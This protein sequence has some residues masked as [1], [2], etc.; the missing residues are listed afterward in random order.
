MQ[1][2]NDEEEP[3]ITVGLKTHPLLA[4]HS[5][6]L[7]YYLH[8]R[9]HHFLLHTFATII[10]SLTRCILDNHHLI[11]R[12]ITFISYGYVLHIGECEKDLPVV[13]VF[14]WTALGVHGG[15]WLKV[16]MSRLLPKKCGSKDLNFLSWFNALAIAVMVPPILR[17]F[18]G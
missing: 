1:T 5:P 8:A 6:Y 13:G 18:S 2:W 12:P 11:T 14:V 16:A 17:T 10:T 9:L 7:L 4:S 15:H 3:P